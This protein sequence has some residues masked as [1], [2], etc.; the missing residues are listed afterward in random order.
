MNWK[1]IET[2]PK[3]GETILLNVP[4]LWGKWNKTLPLAGRWEE[5]DPP[6]SGFW[7]IFNA[8]EVIQRVE[9]THWMLLPEAPL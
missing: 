7:I 1:P 2:A 8:D 4:T 5:R 3:N 6:A 9:P